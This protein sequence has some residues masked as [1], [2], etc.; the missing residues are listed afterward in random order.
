[1]TDTHHFRLLGCKS[2]GRHQ[3]LGVVLLAALAIGAGP[4]DPSY[5][6]ALEILDLAA[7]DLSAAWKLERFTHASRTTSEL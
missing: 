1:M 6:D 7:L 2:R 3:V 5:P 4:A